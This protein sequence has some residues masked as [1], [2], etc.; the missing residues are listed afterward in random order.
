MP[1]RPNPQS[2]EGITSR[3]TGMCFKRAANQIGHLLGPLDLQ[4]PM[5]D[6]PIAI[7]LFGDRF[8]IASRSIPPVLP[9]SNVMMS[10][11]SLFRCGSATR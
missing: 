10:A 5:V 11:S 3:S 4:V 6:D 8:P 9:H 7:F 1:L 2:L